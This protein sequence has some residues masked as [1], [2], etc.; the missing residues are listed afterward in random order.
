MSTKKKLKIR[1]NLTILTMMIEK[2]FVEWNEQGIV[3]ANKDDMILDFGQFL[4]MK[5]YKDSN[6]RLD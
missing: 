3:Y 6:Q 2:D 1:N 4:I 5:H